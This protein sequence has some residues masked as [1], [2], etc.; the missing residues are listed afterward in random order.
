M[1][2]GF[3]LIELLA[4]IVILAIIA[5]IAVPIVLNIIN[6]SKSSS[7]LRSADFYLEGAET[8]I[9]TSILNNI[10][11]PD[12]TY[13]IMQNG[14][15]CIGIINTDNTCNGKI[16]EV[17]IDGE[18]P[19]EGTITIT[20][21]NIT[22]LSITLNQK[23]IYKNSKGELVY[24]KFLD[25]VCNPSKEQKY[26]TNPY[27]E[28]YKY[29]C[30]VDPNEKPYTFY[31]LNTRNAAGEII[32]SESTDK[33]AVLINLIMAQN[34]NSDGSPTTKAIKKVDKDANGGIYNL[35]AWASKENYDA[36]IYYEKMETVT[37]MNFLQEATKNWANA[38]II[39]NSL[40]SNDSNPK[41]MKVYN[42]YARMPYYNE[43]GNSNGT[44]EY[45]YENLAGSN[46]QGIEGKQPTNT[47]NGICGYWTLSAY[48]NDPKFAWRVSYYGIVNSNV[49]VINTTNCGVRPVINLKI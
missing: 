26:A 4:V 33:K 2:K 32:T 5:V 22:G 16:L 11:V 44:N 3:T 45:L 46:W 38:N 1:K 14:N 30:K 40:D 37:A 39:I 15:I 24:A 48:S 42:T 17:E 10:Q 21:G 47:I 27:D 25:E 43:L 31:V 13:S 49:Q 6:D 35:V 41:N 23:E 19:T 28:G 34:I 7:T 18:A 29:E 12:G 20:N 8:S 9:A 36:D